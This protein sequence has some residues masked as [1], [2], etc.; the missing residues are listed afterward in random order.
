MMNA[1]LVDQESGQ[2]D[3]ASLNRN[4]YSYVYLCSPAHS[5]STL[6]A[7]LG[8]AHPNISTVGE[9]SGIFRDTG[10]CSCSRAYRDCPFWKAW[11]ELAIANGMSFTPGCPDRWLV[12]RADSSRWDGLFNHYFPWQILDRLRDIAFL[13]SPHRRGTQNAVAESLRIAR[14]LCDHEHTSVFLDTTKM[15][16]H[17]R[18]LLN[19]HEMTLKVIA[20]VRDGRGAVQSLMKWYG[21][22]LDQAVSDWL[23]SIRGLR[24]AIRHLPPERVLHLRYEDLA[25]NPATHLPRLYEFCGVDPHAPL[26][27]SIEKRHIVGNAM[28]HKFDG[29]IRHDE[30]WRHRLTAEQLGYFA[31]RAGA[32]NRSLGYDD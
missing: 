23:Y 20:L 29:T 12:P 30:S 3:R 10:L 17:P 13:G 28:R 16:F 2:Q 26:D 22:S 24:R 9:L 32:V 27:Y 21:K 11:V 18:F 19:Q 1:A 5:G 15:S 25:R 14:L 6:V 8:A 7:C 4:D 31:A